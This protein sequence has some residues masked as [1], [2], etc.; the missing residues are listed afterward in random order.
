MILGVD[1]SGKLIIPE[2][3]LKAIGLKENDSANIVINSFKRAIVINKEIPACIFCDVAV[4]LISLSEK[5]VCARCRDN[6]ANAKIGD[7]FY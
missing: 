3:F 1:S 6:L 7:C 5:Y 2:G 4:D